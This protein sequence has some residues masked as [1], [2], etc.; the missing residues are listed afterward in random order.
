MLRRSLFGLVILFLSGSSLFA[1]TVDVRM[2]RSVDIGAK[3]LQVVSTTDGQRIYVL[4]ETGEVQMYTATGQ[5]QGS[6]SVG[7]DVTGISTQGANRLILQLG[8]QQQIILL[9]L[10]PTVQ[11]SSAGAPSLGPTDAPVTISLFDDFECPYCAQLVPLVK[12]VLAAY[13]EQVKLVFKNYPLSMHKHARAAATAALA[14]GRQGKF[15]PMHDLLFE[16]YN[17]LN[18]QKIRQLAEQVGLNM[19]QFETDR[20]DQKLQQQINA[21]FQEGQKIGVR[22]TPTI[23]INGRRLPQRSRAAFDQLIQEELAKEK[24]VEAGGK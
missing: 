23:F 10:E 7:T 22:G 6:F 12:E 13:P 8:E 11:I 24:N 17:K 15:W 9:A 5:L 20:I 16:N 21:D 3:P 4:T 18:P 19:A 14:A 1:N 2:L